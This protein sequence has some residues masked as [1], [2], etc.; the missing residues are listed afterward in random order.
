MY[1]RK[2]IIKANIA[3]LLISGINSTALPQTNTPINFAAK[4][5]G[6]FRSNISRQPGLEREE[7]FRINLVFNANKEWRFI[8]HRKITLS[9]D[10]QHHRYDEFR[11]FTRYDQTIGGQFVQNL[12]QNYKFT[13][14][15]DFR[16]RHHPSTTQ[17]N[18]TKNILDLNIKRN[19]GGRT[20]WT[21]GYK[22]WLKSY[23]NNSSLSKYVSH[24]GYIKFNRVFNSRTNFG[25]KFE[26][27]N[28]KGNLYAGS[29]APEQPLNIIGNRYVLRLN[30][31]KVFSSKFVTS[32]SYKFEWDL[33][34]DFDIPNPDG[35][36]G[37]EESDEFIADDSD[38]GYKKH[39]GSFSMHWRANRKISFLFFYLYYT[40]G[41]EHWRISPDGP[42][43]HD[44]VLFFSHQ[45]RFKLSKKFGVGIRH[46][47]ETNRT[48]LNPYRYEIHSLSAGLNFTP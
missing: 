46:N 2:S 11:N 40:K 37:D 34:D 41:F 39:L 35:V 42:K 29:T 24:R 14:S 4:I 7:D 1:I 33:A 47:F 32:A 18:Y 26:Y 44:K 43:R 25:A 19:P 22:N 6:E 3:I 45:I 13:L 31:D 23:L 17:F 10:L 8:S 15:N 36:F 27:Q 38:F 5:S 9:Y 48:N 12:A 21:L 28:H 30:L 16:F 20:S